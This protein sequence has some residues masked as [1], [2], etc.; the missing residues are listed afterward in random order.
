MGYGTLEAEGTVLALLAGDQSLEEAGPGT[1]VQVVL[2]R[3]PFYAEGGGQ[4][5]A[6]GPLEWPSG[7]ARVETTLT[8]ERGIF[9]HR[10][11]VEEG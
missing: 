4:I 3:T 8:T 11:K 7:R 9:L 10:A 2:D 1:E 5:G 6:F